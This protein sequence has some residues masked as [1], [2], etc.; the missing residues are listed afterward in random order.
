[1]EEYSTSTDI[2]SGPSEPGVGVFV[3]FQPS[4]GSLDVQPNY[5]RPTTKRPFKEPIISLSQYMV[6]KRN[7]C[8]KSCLVLINQRRIG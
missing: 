8:T 2:F 1:M 3:S 4:H 5:S 6:R 7:D